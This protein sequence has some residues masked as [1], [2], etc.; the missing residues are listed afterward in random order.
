MRVFRSILATSSL[1]LL[2]A[3]QP[4]VP[5]SG[6]EAGFGSS[7]FDG[8]PASGT[9][10]NGDPLVP[11]ARVASEPLPRSVQPA[12]RVAARTTGAGNFGSSSPVTSGSGD[13]IARETAAAL[14]AASG[15]SG[16]APIEASP[17]NP[18]PAIVG[19]PGI[20][21]ENDFDAVASRQS[22]ESDAERL[23]RQRSQYQ[24][25]NPTAVPTRSG[26]Q[27][28]NIV[29]YALSTSNPRGQRI[30][31]RS[32]INL[33]A[34]SSRNCAGYASPELAQI[35]FLEAGG[36][37]RDRKALDPDGDGYACGWDPA[38]YRL[39]VQN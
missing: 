5:E 19:N 25:V 30:Y 33:A 16:S 3:C 36:P 15:N 21:D 23:A 27:D 4:Q 1:V 29:R 11:P 20:S 17:S 34:R 7:P 39:A 13:D 9:T 10:I 28:P 26:S 31:S 6:P 24:V 2:A 37:K 22:I 18:A 14:A 35:A 12:P 38:P 32:G 8:A